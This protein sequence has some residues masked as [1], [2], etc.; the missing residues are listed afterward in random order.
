LYALAL[1]PGGH[2]NDELCG[3][4][5]RLTCPGVEATI[6]IAGPAGEATGPIA[7]EA[8]TGP[9]NARKFLKILHTTG[10]FGMAG[11]IIAYMFL[12]QYGPELAVSADYVNLREAIHLASRWVI[13]P[14]MMFVMVSGLLAMAVHHPFQNA[15]WVWSKALMGL[16]IFEAVLA[17]VDGPARRAAAAARDALEGEMTVEG[18]EAAVRDHWGALWMLL[19]LSVVNVVLAIWRPRMLRPI[20]D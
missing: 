11:G 16:L 7:P 18:L 4:D 19:A 10:S 8:Q 2:K 20:K 3:H 14:S 17:S 5:V 1:A 13:T 9:M 15:L 6:G 12:V